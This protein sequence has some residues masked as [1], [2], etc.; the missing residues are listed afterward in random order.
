[1]D[2][3]RTVVLAHPPYSLD[4]APCNLLLF[5]KLINKFKRQRFNTEEFLV[6]VGRIAGSTER[7]QQKRLSRCLAFM[8][9]ELGI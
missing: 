3:S 4:L 1:M 7:T 6:D 2:K 9:E 5:T 8:T